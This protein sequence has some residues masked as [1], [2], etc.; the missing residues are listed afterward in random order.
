MKYNVGDKVK[1]KEDLL[2]DK[3]KKY[4]GKI[5]TIISKKGDYEYHIDLD[6]G[7]YYWYPYELELY[8]E[9]PKEY[10]IHNLLND[11]PQETL[12]VNSL[13]I[14]CK[15]QDED[16]YCYKIPTKKWDICFYTFR[17]ILNMKFTKVEEPKLKPMTFEEA[18]ETGGRLKFVHTT[19][20]MIEEFMCLDNILQYIST[21][22]LACSIK[23]L[24][25]DS[26]WYA[27]GVYE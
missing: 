26:T 13:G 5:A 14:K 20:K 16:L 19:Y 10:T 25:L 6:Q 12:F 1:I 11:F 22:F 27:E 15:I 4:I 7:E 21:T 18:V 3:F 23:D 9:P 8:I 17:T 2:A 24:I